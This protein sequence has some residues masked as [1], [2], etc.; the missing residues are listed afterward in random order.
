[1]WISN[2]AI[3]R[4]VVTV[5]LMLALVVFGIFAVFQLE[6]DE[7]PEIDAPVV[8]VAIPYPGA[9]PEV[10]EQEAITPIED[11]I[12]SISGVDRITSTSLDGF[13]QIIVEFLFS[14]DTNEAAQDV[15]D[16]ISRIRGELPLELEE[17]ILT[18]FDP[19]DLP[20]V[21][22][23]LASESRSVPQLT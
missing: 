13:G 15:R 20:I 8:A 10:V 9:S 2:F 16:A 11:A 5:V 6:T 18:R 22:L 3:D 19:A 4:P 12:A 21:S 1:M 23:T 14:K 7:F 17:P